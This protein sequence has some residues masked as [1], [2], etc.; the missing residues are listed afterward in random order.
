MTIERV[1]RQQ[2]A[3]GAHCIDCDAVYNITT[4]PYWHWSK[5]MHMHRDGSGH[6]VEMYRIVAA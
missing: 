2:D 5:S 3:Q 1:T 6:K 4:S